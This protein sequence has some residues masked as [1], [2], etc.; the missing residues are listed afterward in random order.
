VGAPPLFA[1][2]LGAPYKWY[3]NDIKLYSYF[4]LRRRANIARAKPEPTLNL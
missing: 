2:Y 4:A 3:L 1:Y